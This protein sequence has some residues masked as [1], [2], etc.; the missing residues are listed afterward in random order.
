MKRLIIVA[1][2]S[3]EHIRKFHIPLIETLKKNGWMVDVACLL[4]E[5]VP[6]AD[7]AYH[8]PY[9]RSPFRGS[10]FVSMR[11][12]RDILQRNQY[13]ILLCNTVVGSAVARLAAAPLRKKGLKVIYLNHGLHFFPGASLLRWVMGYPME[14]GLSRRTDVLITIN[15]TDYATAKRHLKIP[16]I[17][18]CCGMGVNLQR[19]RNA[20]LSPEERVKKRSAL[21]IGAK[22]FVLTYVAEI[23]SNKNQKMLLDA[24]EI[25]RK[26]V[27]NTKLMLIG[28]EHDGGALHKTIHRKGLQKDVLHLGWRNDVPTLLQLADVYVA[29]SKSEGLGL[30]LIEAMAAGLPVVATENRGHAELISSGQNGF[31]VEINDSKAMA[32]CILRLRSDPELQETLTR[33][34]QSTIE[35]FRTETAMRRL[36]EILSDHAHSENSSLV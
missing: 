9:D 22:D 34:A 8:L 4:D 10:L 3:K 6:E 19:F 28:P 36:T 13:D 33:Q 11:M 25:V 14:R 29:S 30:N 27:P 16:V 24:F 7:H 26:T 5:P 12:L 21:G 2:A 31:L 17:A 15:H 35:P 18:Q 32:A 1:N 20:A 23:T